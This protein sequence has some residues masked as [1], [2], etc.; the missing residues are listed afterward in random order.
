MGPLPAA[1]P[2]SF[3]APGAGSRK[4]AR[5]STDASGGGGRVGSRIGGKVVNLWM[6]WGRVVRA[7]WGRWELVVGC[8]N[9]VSQCSSGCNDGVVRPP[10]GPRRGRFQMGADSVPQGGIT[11]WEF[12]LCKTKMLW[13]V[14]LPD[15]RGSV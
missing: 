1:P 10:G 15:T 14:D 12:Q 13:S 6:K 4:G 8:P 5:P 3:P 7:L 11:T 2:G 9:G